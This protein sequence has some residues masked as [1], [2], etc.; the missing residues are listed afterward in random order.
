LCGRRS[1][2]EAQLQPIAFLAA[3]ASLATFFYVAVAVGNYGPPIRKVVLGDIIAVIC[4][5]GAIL[6]YASET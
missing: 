6:L 5:A 2:E 3:A 4:L 1:S